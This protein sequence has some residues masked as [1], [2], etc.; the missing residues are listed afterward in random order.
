MDRKNNEIM[1]RDE[2]GQ[3]SLSK[4]KEAIKLYLEHI[5]SKTKQFSNQI[6]RLRYLVEEDYYIDV[7]KDYSEETLLELLDY[8]Y[9][10]GFEF[11]SFMAASKFYD[12][13]AL[14]LEISRNGLKTLNNIT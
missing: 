1:R 4:D 2:L 9:S 10:F 11:Q 7:F 3:L 5:K 8:A 13:Y 14:K 12:T 6:A